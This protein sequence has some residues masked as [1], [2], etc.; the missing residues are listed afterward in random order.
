[1]NEVTELCIALSALITA[2][3]GV[4]IAIIKMIKSA[5]KEIEGLPNKIR[6]QSGI[7][8][9]I[10]EKMEGLKEYVNA[11]R[12]QV[13]DFHNGGHYANGRSALKTTCTYEVCRSGISPKQKMLEGIPLS[14]IPKFTNKLLE[15]GI[16]EVKVLEDM[17]STMPGTYE[18]K[19]EMGITAFYDIILNNK[20][21]EPIGFLA[22][23][24]VK[25]EYHV[26]RESDKQEVLKLKFFI[27]ENLEKM[28]S[29]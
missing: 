13:Y 12:V 15:D 10:I 9:L 18:L 7:D 29:K 24:Y 21:G 5:K 14:C 28:N 2:T 17:K 3:G 26:L 25:N 27:E 11:D 6:K 23:Q 1:M 4:A 8:M 19:K 20:C 16:F 22:V